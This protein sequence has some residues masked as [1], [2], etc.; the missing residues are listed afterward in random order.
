MQKKQSQLSGLMKNVGLKKRKMTN[1]IFVEHTDTPEFLDVTKEL[2][3]KQ[4]RQLGHLGF[5][6]HYLIR[7]NGEIEKG[8]DIDS[9]A[10]DICEFNSEAIGVLIVG[11]NNFSHHQFTTFKNITTQLNQQYG[12]LKII[13]NLDNKKIC[14]LY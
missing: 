7:L 10:G 14:E 4:H 3:D 8:R 2:L 1:Y 13:T 12:D 6:Y 11:K 9:F 5:R